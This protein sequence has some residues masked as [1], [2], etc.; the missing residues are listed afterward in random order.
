MTQNEM[1]LK[2]LQEGHS[3]TPKE[4]LK[5]FGVMRLAA[6]I[7]NLRAAGHS[8]KTDIIVVPTQ[9]GIANVAKYS[10]GEANA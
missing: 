7:N 10:L 5:K 4:A 9:E 8:I 1:I 3:L 6:R 2:H